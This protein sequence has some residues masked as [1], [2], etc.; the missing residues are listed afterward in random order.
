MPISTARPSRAVAA[1]LGTLPT[2]GPPR[3]APVDRR[4]VG[5][6][7]LRRGQASDRDPVGGAADVVHPG[8]MAEGDRT[9]LAAMLTADPDLEVRP[10]LPA[11]RD[12]PENELAHSFLVKSVEGVLRQNPETMLVDILGEEVTGVIAGERHRHLCQV[13]RAEGEELRFPGD[14]PR[15][16]GGARNLDHRADRIADP[17]TLL[18]ENALTDLAR[19]LR[20]DRDLFRIHH[21]W[22]HDLRLHRDAPAL[23]GRRRFEDGPYLHLQDLRI[24]QAKTA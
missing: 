24:G 19:A 11:A 23:H 20:Q 2:G 13:V 6:G 15:Q 22:M 12:R 14:P 21:Q 3:P 9:R 17:G 7:G 1:P 16:Q 8:A 10:R 5:D 4:S 18:A